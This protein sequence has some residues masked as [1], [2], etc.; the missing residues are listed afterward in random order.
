MRQ[1][2]FITHQTEKYTYLQSAQIALEGGCRWIQLRMKGVAISEVEDTAQEVLELCRRHGATFIIDD[3][4]ATALKLGAD[5]VHLG[6]NDMPIASARRLL[7][8]KYIIGGT[9]NT[10]EDF[11]RLKRE[12]AD[13]VGLGPFRFTTTKQNLSPVLGVEG[14][15]RIMQQCADEG[16]HLPVVAIGGITIADIPAI[17]ETGVGGVAISSAILQAPDPV[18]E[19]RRIIKLLSV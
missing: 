12:G 2:Q 17:L 6:K 4:A 13:Y 10:F 15:R 11:R 14:Y 5:G 3:L 18:L 7:G 1:L 9:A 19:T 16:I 8:E